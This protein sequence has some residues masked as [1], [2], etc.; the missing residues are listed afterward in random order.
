LKSALQLG[1]LR[2]SRHAQ[3]RRR[4]TPLPC[5]TAAADDPLLAARQQLAAEEGEAFRRAGLIDEWVVNGTPEDGYLQLKEAVAKWRPDL[6]PSAAE[7]ERLHNLKPPGQA[8]LLLVGP[9]GVVAL[10]C[11]GEG[12]RAAAAS[13]TWCGGGC[14]YAAT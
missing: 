4:H 7:L 1:G 11:P 13:P 3:A 9:A 6:I 14:S 5:R 12:G 8:P 10:A 2:P